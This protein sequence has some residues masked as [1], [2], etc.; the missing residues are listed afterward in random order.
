[1]D[2]HRFYLQLGIITL[3][4]L[5]VLILLRFFRVLSPSFLFSV[6]SLAFFVLLS[7]GMYFLAIRAA[8]SKDKNAFS[9]L[10]MGFTFG[11]MFLTVIL[12]VV[13]KKLANPESGFFLIPFFLIY[14]VFTIFETN[15]MTKLGK[16]KAR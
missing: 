11:K 2:R 8:V 13:Y 9:R 6:I 1:M 16:I 14:I 7:A 15:F 10:I 3:S 5:G 12:V 4:L